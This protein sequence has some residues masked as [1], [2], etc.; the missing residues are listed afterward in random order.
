MSDFDTILGA[1]AAI[2]DVV[3]KLVIRGFGYTEIASKKS[4]LGCSGSYLDFLSYF[5]SG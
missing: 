3:I 4:K 2:F 1:V 5:Y